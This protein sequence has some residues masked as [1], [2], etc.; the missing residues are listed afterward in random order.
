VRAD[1]V[2]FTRAGDSIVLL[3]PGGGTYFS[4]SD[5]GA[6]IWELCD[7]RHTLREIAEHL[8]EDYDAPLDEILADARELVDELTGAGLLADG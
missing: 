3:D 1:R 2:S 5:V 4:L 8:A 6:E 7:G